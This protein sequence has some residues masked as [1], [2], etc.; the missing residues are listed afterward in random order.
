MR[1]RNFW[2]GLVASL[3]TIALAIGGLVLTNAAGD[4]E[5]DLPDEVGGL[6]ALDDPEAFPDRGSPNDGLV[7][8]QREANRYAAGAY[9]DA[10]D[11]AAAAVRAYIRADGEY[12]PVQVTAI[13]GDAGPL[14]PDVGFTSPEVL[15]FAL[16]LVERITDGD[17]ECLVFRTQPPR[18]GTDYQPDR[19]APDYHLCQ[20]SSGSLTIRVRASEPDT[21]VVV[22]LV[23][24]LWRELD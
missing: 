15:G 10:F 23:D 18:A 20:R 14:V 13:A 22:D 21:D 5:I 1:S 24:D 12:Q 6:I 11:G 16:P 8:S 19:A 3:A 7:D 4:D 17:V 2:I 9:S